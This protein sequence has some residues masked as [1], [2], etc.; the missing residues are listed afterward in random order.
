MDLAAKIQSSV[1][2]NPITQCWEWKLQADREGYGR[3]TRRRR[4]AE[5]KPLKSRT[6]AAHRA[7]YEAFVGPIPCGLVIDH[8]C[9]NTRCVNPQHLEAVTNRENLLRAARARYKTHCPKGHQL[10]GENLYVWRGTRICRSC[11]RI[12]AKTYHAK[13][14]RTQ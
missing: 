3:L 9:R 6:L 12:A 7:S 10:S 5:G 11:N 13:K 1:A 14:A 8:L 4:D 2:I